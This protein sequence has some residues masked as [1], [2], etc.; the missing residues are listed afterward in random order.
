[1]GMSS[2]LS[3]ALSGMRTTQA[4]LDLVSRN[5]ANADLPGYTKK[6]LDQSAMIAGDRVVG[7]RTGDINRQ[8]DTFVLRQMR[9]ESSGA[10]Y[11]N[12]LSRYFTH[13][14]TTLG[15]PGSPAGLDSLYNSFLGSLDAL[16]TS[17]DSATVRD[18]VLR[19]AQALAQTLNQTSAEIQEMRQEAE[20]GIAGA[21]KQINELLT[22]IANVNLDISSHAAGGNPPADLL[23]IRDKHIAEL[24][25][26]IDL[27]V[28]ERDG[29]EVALFTQSGTSL[30]D[31]KPAELIFDERG[32]LNAQTT[33]STDPQER[34]VG[35]VQLKSP[36][37]LI[38]DLI[39]DGTVRSGELAAL[40]ELR[41]DHLV[42]AQ[43][44]LD[45]FADAMARALSANEVEGRM[46][47][48]GVA[49]DPSGMQPGDRMSLVY[50][51]GSEQRTITFV[52]GDPDKVDPSDYSSPA[53]NEDVVIIPFGEW[54][55]DPAGV[56]QVVANALTDRGLDL[57]VEVSSEGDLEFLEDINHG[58]QSLGMQ[59]T[60]TDF[61]SGLGL[62]VFV[63]GDGDKPYSAS[64]DGTPQQTGFS[65]R[66]KVNPKL[67]ADNS[68]LVRFAEDTPMGDATRPTEILR[69][70]GQD[71]HH[72]SS[73][74]GVSGTTAYSGTVGGY[75]QRVI[76]MQAN[77]QADATRAREAQ[78]VVVSQLEERFSRESGVNID[79][80]MARLIELQTAFQANTRVIQS[81]REMLAM[82]MQ[83]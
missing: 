3:S 66:I 72:F 51:D 63:D 1:M 16:T 33:Y 67:L 39:A 65:G 60:A 7:V 8:L 4:G 41:D 13:L 52:S 78:D 29:G 19:D 83:M 37:G 22:Q 71:Q 30:L 35:A 12:T 43:S 57:D 14:D 77:K 17:P 44:Q 76:S 53:P 15:S 24:S 55:A 42:Q 48:G 28:L 47:S 10:G 69:R 40:I 68:R 58:V 34:G 23:D 20:R 31:G 45:A 75:L 56:R 64:L 82:L 70:L 25:K 2:I 81:Y 46:I 54:D 18:K 79:E 74:L 49:I 21:V 59:I 50:L 6:A 5:V 80:E 62:P 38:V 26:L 9:R 61:E 36:S 73:E 32:G 27:K 11:V